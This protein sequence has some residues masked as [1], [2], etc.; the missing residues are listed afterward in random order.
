M[1]AITV[2]L[3]ADQLALVQR[4]VSDMTDEVIRYRKKAHKLEATPEAAESARKECDSDIAACN[5]LW[6]LL[7]DSNPTGQG[8]QS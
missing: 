6:R 4:A 2:T 1:S 3:T 7:E 8:R 5:A